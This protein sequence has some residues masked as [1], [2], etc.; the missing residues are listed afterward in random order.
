MSWPVASICASNTKHAGI[1][2][3]N[4]GYMHPWLSRH[5]VTTGWKR[6]SQCTI[7]KIDCSAPDRHV[8]SVTA[9]RWPHFT[10][11]LLAAFLFYFLCVSLHEPYYSYYY[12][13]VSITELGQALFILTQV[14]V[15]TCSHHN[16]VISYKDLAFLELTIRNMLKWRHCFAGSPS[17]HR[18]GYGHED[19]QNQQQQSQHVERSPAHEPALPSQHTQ[20]GY[21]CT[22]SKGFTEQHRIDSEN[23]QC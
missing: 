4:H 19:E 11:L 22:L 14:D 6:K 8:Y 21:T 23:I 15:F 17:S 9:G 1:T 12:L 7:I 10:S 18:P 2:P 5:H 3:A 16:T 13:Q 20:V